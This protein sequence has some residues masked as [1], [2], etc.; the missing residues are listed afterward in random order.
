MTDEKYAR[1]DKRL[2]EIQRLANELRWEISEMMPEEH[3]AGRETLAHNSEQSRGGD[4][5][6]QSN[7]QG[8]DVPQET[9]RYRQCTHCGTK[10]TGDANI[11]P[12]CGVGL[13]WVD[14][15]VKEL[16]RATKKDG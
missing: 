9:A 1:M 8:P 3:V 10:W 14:V 6:S 2:M 5:V 7:A 4:S 15:P 16:S 11:C 12:T 13:A